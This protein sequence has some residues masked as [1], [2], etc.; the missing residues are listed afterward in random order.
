MLTR[1]L[2]LMTTLWFSF[3]AEAAQDAPSKN[4]YVNDVDNSL[5]IHKIAVL[6][7]TDNVNSLYGRSV[8]DK[9]KSLLSQA[10]RFEVSEPKNIDPSKTIDQYE[11]QANLVK[12]VAQNSN[13]DAL[14][15]A[16][17]LK[18]QNMVT[19]K[20]DLFL[21]ADGFLLAQ[22][23]AQ[24]KNRYS[25]Q[26]V[27]QV[28][29]D[30]YNKLIKKI[31]YDGL[32]LSREG[33][34]V[35]VDIGTLDGIAKD[36]V[37]TVEQIIAINRHPKFH[38][39][40]SA[41]RVI[42]GKVKLVKVDETLSFGIVLDEKEAGVISADGKFS[43][44]DFINYT[45]KFQPDSQTSGSGNAVSFKS[46]N[47]L[48]PLERPTFGKVGVALGI[49]SF[50]S[51]LSFQSSGSY[52]GE[53]PFYPQLALS[54]EIWITKNW[55]S[56][57]TIRQGTTSQ[58][59]STAG[60]VGG[61]ATTTDYD[62]YAGYKFLLQEDDFWGPQINTHLGF[63]SNSM[64]I[65]S[66]SATSLSSTRYSGMYYG[67]GGSVPANRSRSIYL[68]LEFNR[69]FSPA[70][71]ETPYSSGATSDSSAMQIKFGGAFEFNHHV[72]LGAHIFSEFYSS[73]FS[74]AGARS[75]DTGLN[76]SQ[77]MTALFSSLD[78]LF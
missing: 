57:T 34:R 76:S 10:H 31:P 70:F 24:L 63:S 48:L 7:V 32:I 4:A 14:I 13:V 38:I 30:I 41:E 33:N 68:D 67:I 20:L 19:L 55:Y 69:F 75:Q 73:T 46:Q 66:A 36:T 52:E 29:R 53:S 45:Q 77:S 6:P 5:T 2:I 42:I 78:Y 49:G 50:R 16:H 51:A 56:G 21:K 61:A 54:G 12:S 37:I 43:G 8:E 71:S 23:T 17:I 60:S 27:E 11:S 64:T 62:L 65:D 15:G 28:T 25:T 74:G 3:V 1:F 39:L 40:L 47:E 58:L 72:W 44:L 35:T 22:E 9:I 18:D 26:D 59:Q